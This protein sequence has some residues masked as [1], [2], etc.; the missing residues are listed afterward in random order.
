MKESPANDSGA[1]FGNKLVVLL[2][3][4]SVIYVFN[5]SINLSLE[6]G[7][8]LKTFMS[9]TIQRTLFYKARGTMNW[10]AIEPNLL[11]TDD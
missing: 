1:F 4:K 3:C 7:S 10:L 5:K 11:V 2:Q 8:L 6:V 9:A